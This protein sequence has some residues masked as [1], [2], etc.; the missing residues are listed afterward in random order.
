MICNQ[1]TKP[2][3]IWCERPFRQFRALAALKYDEFLFAQRNATFKIDESKDGSITNTSSL[4]GGIEIQ[5]SLLDSIDE[6]AS[7][8]S[9]DEYEGPQNLMDDDI[10]TFREYSDDGASDVTASSAHIASAYNPLVKAPRTANHLNDSVVENMKLMK[11]R[12]PK[13]ESAS[14]SKH[15]FPNVKSTTA[16]RTFTASERHFEPDRRHSWYNVDRM[17]GPQMAT[18]WDFFDF[19]ED[20]N[21]HFKCPFKSCL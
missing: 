21:G 12:D 3:G 1:C 14:W 8:G 6:K 5:S 20:I 17:L 4:A 15:L 16:P 2:N 18:D 19:Q 7:I 9:K 11:L 10:S 13:S